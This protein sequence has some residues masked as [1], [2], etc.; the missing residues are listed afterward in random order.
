MPC[1]SVWVQN[2]SFPVIAL[3]IQ[4]PLIFSWLVMQIQLWT[5]TWIG[6]QK[7]LASER[8]IS[9]HNEQE[10]LKVMSSCLQEVR[11]LESIDVCDLCTTIL[12]N[13]VGSSPLSKFLVM[14]DIFDTHS[15]I[16]G[17]ATDNQGNPAH[18]FFGMMLDL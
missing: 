2:P 7:A 16:D 17:K 13:L 14:C 6:L 4:V 15:Q 9:A 3:V 8:L 10:M 11:L 12:L 18:P 5:E 1:L